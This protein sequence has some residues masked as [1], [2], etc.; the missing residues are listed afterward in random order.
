MEFVESKGGAPAHL[1]E[2]TSVVQIYTEHLDAYMGLF[3]SL[4]FLNCNQSFVSIY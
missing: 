4:C 2:H 1:D 3:S